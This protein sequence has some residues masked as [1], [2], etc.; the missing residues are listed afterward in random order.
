MK[1]LTTLALLLFVLA[2]IP[3]PALAEAPAKQTEEKLYYETRDDVPEAYRWKLEDIFDSL[4]SWDTAAGAFES[5][6]PELARFK[7]KLA[8][9]ADSLA[10]ALDLRY[11]LERSL[12]DL[13]VYASQ[14]QTSDTRNATANQYQ[15]R[16]QQLAAKFGQATAFIAPEL[17][18]IPDDR[19]QAYLK[20]ERVKVY[21]HVIAD[22]LRSREHLRSDE[23]EQ[24][25][26]AAS[27]LTGAPVGI[28]QGLVSADISWPE[29]KA[30]NG[31]QTRAIP[32][33][34][35]TFMG[36]Q[37]RRVRRDAALALFG[38]YDQFG[39]ALAKTYAA[40]VNKDVWLAKTRH[41]GSSLEMALDQSNVPRGVVDN[42]VATVHE[43]A[44]AVHDYVALRKQLLGIEEFH[45]YD[46]YVSMVP[47][48]EKRY[49]FDE[50][51]ALAMSF[52]KE[53]YGNEYAGVAAK[54][55][56]DRWVDVYPNAGKQGGAY[57]WGSYN[58]HPYLFLNWGGTLEDVFTLVHEMGHSIH[59][60]LANEA[61][62]SHDANYGLFVAEVASV[63]S[64][65]LFFE[66]LYERTS[67]P[68]ERLSLLNLRMNNI[69]GTFLRQIFFHEF[70]ASAHAAAEAG[71][72]LT[73]DALGKI[74]GD[75]WLAYYGDG[76][77]LDEEYRAGWARI[78]HFYRSFYVLK[79]ATSF[80]AGE[81]I[82]SRVRSG[83]KSAVQ[84]YLAA[85]KLGGS[86]YPMD[87]I[88]RAGVD[89]N[90]P[91]VIR[92]VMDRYREILDEMKK[93]RP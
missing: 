87:A 10:S 8:D 91:K 92:A 50:G 81:A 67:D 55:L 71:Q 14:W 78:P 34:F 70:E 27:L 47:E 52:W 19:L 69:T 53:T 26:A 58:S 17:T 82:A 21:S 33:L 18:Q 2:S 25:L 60:Y 80:A 45:I 90:D 84:D 49:R 12:D 31:Q 42:L 13:Y 76:A 24:V 5:K 6:L 9:S 35:Y 3:L 57:S 4:D 46:L 32:A 85:L 64:E 65:S 38:S 48:A 75:L 79:Y 72:A 56:A 37:D 39:H 1:N 89:L 77:T 74:W 22:I 86:V 30:E 28:Y 93:L 59:T 54:A 16:A 73:K 15:G 62:P 7:G 51:W 36:S 88:K 11:E 63:A 29:F 20:Q 23:V 66:W 83:D 40:S 41:Y 68:T 44:D 61:N 43:N